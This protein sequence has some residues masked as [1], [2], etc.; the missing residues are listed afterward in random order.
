MFHFRYLTIIA[1][2]LRRSTISLMPSTAP[3]AHSR[4]ATIPTMMAF[5]QIPNPAVTR[6][7]PSIFRFL[8]P[9]LHTERPQG[10]RD[11]DAYL[12]DLDIVRI[13]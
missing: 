3:I 12:R 5:I 8:T 10:L 9:V 11:C 13:Q 2:Q 6:V 1:G 7:R 4:G